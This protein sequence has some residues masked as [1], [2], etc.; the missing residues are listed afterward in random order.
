M[1]VISGTFS[2]TIRAVNRDPVWVSNPPALVFKSG[3]PSKINIR[4]YVSDGD[5]DELEIVVTGGTMEDAPGLSF[6]GTDLVFDGRDIGR[7]N[8]VGTLVFGAD[9]G[10]ATEASD[11]N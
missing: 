7:E 9:D 5:G 1:L 2:F 11:P 8:V 4:Q 6:D 3:V 10:R